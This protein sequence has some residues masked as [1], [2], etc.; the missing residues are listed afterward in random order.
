MATIFD[1]CVNIVDYNDNDIDSGGGNSTHTY[2][3]TQ[4]TTHSAIFLA[5]H[6]CVM[7]PMQYTYEYIYCVTRLDCS[8]AKHEKIGASAV[9][10]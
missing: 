2:H 8:T 7:Y 4:P 5:S 9:L 3:F 1:I 10:V 6:F